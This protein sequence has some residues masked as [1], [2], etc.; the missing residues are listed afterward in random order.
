MGILWRKNMK[1]ITVP[2]NKEAMERLNYNRCAD[3]DLIDIF[4]NDKEY[5]ELWDSGF[6]DH[7]NQS[8]NLMILKMKQ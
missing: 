8:L 6:L 7:L 5:L 1:C 2:I 3:D 4:L